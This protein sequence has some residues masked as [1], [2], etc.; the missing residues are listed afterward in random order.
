MCRGCVAMA[1][2]PGREHTEALGAE[3]VGSGEVKSPSG[4]R[5][6]I[7]LPK[8][9]GFSSPLIKPSLVSYVFIKLELQTCGCEFLFSVCAHISTEC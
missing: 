6:I 1:A 3:A 4:S 7:L 5:S 9:V 2:A 8:N